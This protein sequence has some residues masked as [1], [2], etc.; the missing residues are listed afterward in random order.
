MK[1]SISRDELLRGTTRTQSVVERRGTLPILANVLISAEERD[2]RL[3][4]TDLEVGIVSA[5]PADV[6]EVGRITLAGRKLHEIVRELDQEEVQIETTSD[7]RVRIRAGS[8][9]F[10]LLSVS[11]DEYPSLPASEGAAFV[12]LEASLLGALIDRTLYA[13][14]TDE[15]RYHLNGVHIETIEGGRLRVV[16][17]DGH[18]LALADATPS[19]AVASVLTASVIVPRKGVAEIRRLCDDIEGTVEIGLHENFLLVRRP[20]L[21][22]SA[23]L[24]DAQF[25]NYQ[26]V[27]PAHTRIRVTTHRERLLHGVRRI[28]LVATDR[29]GGFTI[30]VADH[31]LRLSATN[32]DLGE[33]H[34]EIPVEYTGE[35]FATAFDAR[36]VIE[37]LTS[38][39]SKEIVIEFTDELSPAQM[40]PADSVDQIA[41]IMPMRL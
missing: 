23:R 21:V 15:T 36:Y 14:S 27:L 3:S 31:Q 26:G 41:V 20:G 24:I 16:A 6:Q 32:P 19:A 40:R 33:V 4:A 38:L 11:A 30:R 7:S 17:T 35:P 25:P 9:D 5:H 1:L 37:A 28:A 29:S 34:E 39:A 10:S 22:L 18:R 2:V 13:T 12:P 8:A